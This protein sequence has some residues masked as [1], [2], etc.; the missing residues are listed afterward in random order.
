[1]SSVRLFV[2]VPEAGRHM[3]AQHKLPVLVY[4]DPSDATVVGGVE[5]QPGEAISCTVKDQQFGA[6][7]HILWIDNLPQD[8]NRALNIVATKGKLDDAGHCCVLRRHAPAKAAAAGA[9]LEVVYPTPNAQLPPNFTTYGYVDPSTTPVT[10]WLAD[11]NGNTYPGMAIPPGTYDWCFAFQSIPTG[12]YNLYVQAADNIPV[13]VPITVVAGPAPA[14][15][16]AAD[17]AAVRADGP[18][19]AG[20]R[21]NGQ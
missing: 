13:V 19:L 21:I 2:H 15:P 16:A 12:S 8:K 6:F 4:T 18:S 14:A 20:T 11:G 3:P 7:N 5:N 17:G 9:T 1:M 10:A